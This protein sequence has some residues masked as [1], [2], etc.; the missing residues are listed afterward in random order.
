MKRLI[1]ALLLVL[2]PVT[3]WAQSSVL[4]GGSWTP[5][6]VPMYSGSGGITQPTVQQSGPASGGERSISEMS[7]IKRGT[8]TPPYTGQ[9]SGYLGSIF[10]LYDGPTSGAYHQLCMDANATGN[11]GLLS[12]NAFNG[13]TE[14]PLKFV[15]N[16]Q[17]Y[18]FPFAISGIIGPGS[19]TVN[20]VV[21]WNNVSGTL[22]S[23]CGKIGALI[24]TTAGGS[25]DALT[26][27][28]SATPAL[29]AGQMVTV[30]AASANT[31]A[32]P[33]LTLTMSTG[34]VVGPLTI[35][36][37][38]GQALLPHDVFAAGHRL[39][40]LYTGT[41]FE[42]LNPA[43]SISADKINMDNLGIG[44]ADDT[45]IW[46]AVDTLVGSNSQLPKTAFVSKQTNVK[47]LAI[48][49]LRKIEGI[50]GVQ[51]FTLTASGGVTDWVLQYKGVGPFHADG[52]SI[53]CPIYNP[54][55]RAQPAG[56][57]AFVVDPQ[58]TSVQVSNVT[59]THM[60]T[61]GCQDAIRIYQ[62]LYT[63]MDDVFNDRPWGFGWV[64]SDAKDTATS[65]TR[66]IRIRNTYG[67]NAGQYCGSLPANITG[68]ILAPV[69][70]DVRNVSCDGAGFINS[71]LC[72]DFTGSGYEK[73][74]FEGTGRNCFAGGIEAKN[75][76][77]N[78]TAIPSTLSSIYVNFS[79]YSNYD[80]GTGVNFIDFVPNG[81][82]KVSKIKGRA[83]TTFAL[84]QAR[85]EST[86]YDAGA[87]F[88]ANG[89]TYKVATPGTTEVGGGP[90]GTTN[91]ITDG[92]AQVDYLQ[93]TPTVAT[94]IAAGAVRSIEDA[95]LEYTFYDT[96]IGVY[97]QSVATFA[98]NR[99]NLKLTG[100][101]TEQCFT[102]STGVATVT[103]LTIDGACTSVSAG[104]F[105]V[106]DF[107]TNSGSSY[108]EVVIKGGPWRQE[109][110]GGATGVSLLR[111]HPNTTF[112]G[113]IMG[114]T[115]M[116]GAMGII[117]NESNPT[118]TVGGGGI[119]EVTN[120]S[121]RA[122]I[123]NT[124]TAA[125]T[126]EATQVRVKA[127]AAVSGATYQ[128]WNNAGAATTAVYG[129]FIRKF[130]AASPTGVDQCNS[131][132]TALAQ[133]PGVGGQPA[134]GWYCSTPGN[135]WTAF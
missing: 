27:T 44:T 28:V 30:S 33:T 120:A 116:V 75:T 126:I 45:S 108:S 13:A 71:K 97:L 101:V 59:V 127:A 92:T 104:G 56:L 41:G 96:A 99:V 129:R 65:R 32:T 95:D 54:V 134:I 1:V 22:V 12:Y 105:P 58:D 64:V 26:S 6:R 73:V 51:T 132:D 128:A 74:I 117:Y 89:N 43:I 24:G 123:H 111:I 98:T 49:N 83:F 36:K 130:A 63:Y 115:H 7:M 87:V 17:S 10:C 15:L 57:Y 119:W 40:F 19:T 34:T 70:I 94:T 86:Y 20:D 90:S 110:T 47:R 102:E 125:G 48:T 52:L 60:R 23:D 124:T 103:K 91:G 122:P 100:R 11:S 82:P 118:I 67:V 66:H 133:A 46:Q 106:F 2:L 113:T 68:A 61:T 38:G 88:T 78:V 53:V 135:T 81:T 29:S 62:S 76:G 39:E 131:G 69:D 16:G 14:Q 84:P 37:N 18:E 3:G 25:A 8:G 9:G 55:T 93:A 107:G 50:K 114:G 85:Q 112:T 21:C 79:Y 4:Q 72:F 77:T 80:G 31:T 5:G 35:T 42:L 109:L 121:A